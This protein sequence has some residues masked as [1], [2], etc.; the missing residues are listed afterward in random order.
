MDHFTAQP[1][2]RCAGVQFLGDVPTVGRSLAEA[3]SL[4]A[5]LCFGG[6]PD[7]LTGVRTNLD[8]IAGGPHLDDAAAFLGAKAQKDRDAALLALVKLLASLAGEYDLVLLD[9]P[10]DFFSAETR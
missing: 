9:C 4:A 5:S 10:P 2:L 6:E 8:V 1:V 3:A 7:L